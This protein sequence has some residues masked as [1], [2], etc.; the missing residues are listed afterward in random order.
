MITHYGLF[1]SKDD[2]YWGR[3]NDPGQLLGKP[4]G[5]NAEV[6][7]YREFIGVYCLYNSG[8]LIYIGKAGF[9]YKEKEKKIQFNGHNL[10]ERLKQH[11]LTKNEGNWDQ[12]SWFGRE[13]EESTTQGTDLLLTSLYHLEAVTIAMINPQFNRQAGAF[14]KAIKVN[15]FAHDKAY[16]SIDTRIENIDEKLKKITEKL[17]ISLK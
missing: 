4:S 12:F 9:S 14:H 10:F 1:W 11:N 7:N 8:Q 15:Q 2:V 3:P 5:K 13:R 6:A 17:G 16:G